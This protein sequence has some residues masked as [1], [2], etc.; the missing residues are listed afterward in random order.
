M[1][2]FV[3]K[4]TLSLVLVICLLL[5][6]GITGTYAFFTIGDDDSANGNGGCFNVDYTSSQNITSLTSAPSYDSLGVGIVTVTLKKNN[7]CK[8]YTTA[9]IHLNT[10]STNAPITTV[11]AFKY[12]VSSS[13]TTINSNS[14]LTNNIEGIIDST[15]DIVLAN[16]DLTTSTVTYTIYLW[17][18]SDISSGY[19]SGKNYSG[20]IY[21]ESTQSSGVK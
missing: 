1:K 17:V 12:R 3:K 11:K 20:Y 4:N 16:V 15:G 6:I 10:T 8:A 2:D 5:S 7:S 18:D 14:S 9:N 13:A 21:A 19:Y